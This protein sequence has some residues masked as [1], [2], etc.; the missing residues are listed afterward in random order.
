[1]N[2]RRTLVVS[3]L[4][5]FFALLAAACGQKAGVHTTGLAAGANG[6][7]DGSTT[8]TS[9]DANGNVI[10]TATGQVVGTASGGAAGSSGA[11]GS[12]GG[13]AGSSGGRSTAGGGGTSAA[14]GPGDR[15]GITTDTIRIGI[16]APASGA[17]APATSFNAGKQVYFD[18]IGKTINGRQ[19]QVSFADDAYNPSSAVAAC[20]KLVQ[21]DKVFLLVGGGGTDQIVACA[22]Y[23]AS[24]GVPYLAEGVTENGLSGLN[25]YFAESMTYKAQALILAQYIKKQGYTKVAMVRGNTANFDDAHS[26]FLQGVQQ[27]GLTMVKGGDIA[28][29]K[30]AS[31]TEVSTAVS[32]VCSQRAGEA[33]DKHDLAVFPLMSPKLFI[34][35]AGAAAQQFQ[36]FPRYAGIGI[37]LGLNVVAQAVCPT[38]G[39]KTG[40]TFFSPFQGL[41]AANAVDPDYQREYQKRNGQAGD[42]IGFGLWGAEKLLAAEL[43]LAGPNISRQSFVASLKGKTFTTGVYPVV[44]FATGP[45]GGT[46]TH[47]LKAD[48][49]KSQYVT[50]SQNNKGF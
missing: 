42:D 35:F 15:T 23:A 45:F 46:A 41:D 13:A 19:V 9:V 24:V 47:V 5:V 6:L 28:I 31:A 1:V 12:A 8:A 50:E 29:N 22:K 17:G 44:N 32:Q 34:N 43:K 20:K 25:G 38:T 11:T 33:T 27:A 10:D 14:S 21:Q 49:S 7:S 3:A 4:I 2:R 48:C 40:A 30:D 36:C 26:G 18:F 39:F 16:H 37:T